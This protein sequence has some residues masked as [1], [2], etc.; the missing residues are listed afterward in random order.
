M[1]C[2]QTRI[3]DTDP[4]YFHEEH[5]F[6]DVIQQWFG[7]RVPRDALQTAGSVNYLGASLSADKGRSTRH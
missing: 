1:V 2:K 6:I 7:N 4:G 3:T 5:P